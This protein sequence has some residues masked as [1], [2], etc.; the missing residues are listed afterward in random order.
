MHPLHSECVANIKGRDEILALLGCLGAVYATL[1]YFDSNR[2]GWLFLSSF[3]LL[4]GMLSKENALTFLFVVPLTVWAFTSVPLSRIGAATIPLFIAVVIF[5]LVRFNA[6]GFMLDHGKAVTDLMNDPFLDM[7]LGQKLATIFLTLGWY[8]K[9]L[10]VP[11]P[12]THD[13]YPYHVPK[14]GWTDWRAIASLVL[15]L[16]MG[17][18]AVLNIG[19]KRVMAYSILCWIATL[20]IVSNIFVSVGSFMNERFAYMPSIA[21][22][23]A[24]GWFFAY[25][26]PDWIIDNNY[27]YTNVD[28]SGVL[29]STKASGKG[30]P[31]PISQQTWGHLR[32]E[33]LHL[34]GC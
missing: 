11:Y 33:E 9:L 20:S 3:C 5:V 21:F 2:I 24:F 28:L 22:C 30:Q 6:L 19:K 23:L 32:G 10:F 16:G 18:W 34:E 14:V 26:L 15:Y 1:K 13:Y 31:K 17:V 12:L 8:I 27:K 29:F 7:N 25:K 4:L